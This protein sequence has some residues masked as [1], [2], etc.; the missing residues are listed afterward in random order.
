[1]NLYLEIIRFL[2]SLSSIS[3]FFGQEVNEPVRLSPFSWRSSIIWVAR[4]TSPFVMVMQCFISKIELSG[5]ISCKAVHSSTKKS[6][7]S[8]WE[9]V[10]S[11]ESKPDLVI[12]FDSVIDFETSFD[13]GIMSDS[14]NV[15]QKKKF[16]QLMLG[17]AGKEKE[18][19]FFSDAIGVFSFFLSLDIWLPNSNSHSHTFAVSI[20]EKSGK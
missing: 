9:L 10:V 8:L 1:M 2:S 16:H 17:W 5:K 15:L 3:G 13:S 7:F 18:I 20:W 12:S 19:Y 11:F 6:Q 4:S 14:L